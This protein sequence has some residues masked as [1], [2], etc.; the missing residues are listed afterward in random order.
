[1]TRSCGLVSPG[2]Y[3]SRI[4]KNHNTLLWPLL[5]GWHRSSI[6]PKGTQPS[7]NSLQRC[8]RTPLRSLS[9]QISTPARLRKNSQEVLLCRWYC[10]FL[11]SS[12]LFTMTRAYLICA[13]QILS[14]NLIYDLIT[15]QLSRDLRLSV[16]SDGRF[17]G[18]QTGCIQ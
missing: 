18:R 15:A 8:I 9:N 16:V 1:M 14:G 10:F 6:D 17:F 4:M 7:G 3:S 2:Q 5:Y 13:Y 12:L 11:Q